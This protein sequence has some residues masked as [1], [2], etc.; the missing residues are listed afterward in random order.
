[1]NPDQENYW[2]F[3]VQPISIGTS[4]NLTIEII[5]RR[6]TVTVQASNTATTAAVITKGVATEYGSSVER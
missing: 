4:T 2:H 6:K 3:I 1:M 5:Q